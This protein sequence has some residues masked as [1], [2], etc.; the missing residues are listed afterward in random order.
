MIAFH[1]LN[2]RVLAAG[3]SYNDTTM[4]AEADHGFLFRSPD[5]VIAGLAPLPGA[6]AFLDR[7]RARTQV[8][9][10]SDTFE[11]FAAPLMV[12]LGMP[13]DIITLCVPAQRAPPFLLPSSLLLIST[14]T[15]KP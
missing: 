9:L 5:N 8:I 11:Q 15:L 2:Y 7:L 10:L 14:H 4:L 6:T 1:E 13:T 12:H 3:D